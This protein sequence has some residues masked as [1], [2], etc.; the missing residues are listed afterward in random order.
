MPA[1]PRL[2][3]GLVLL[4]SACTTSSFSHPP[5]AQPTDSVTWQSKLDVR[6]PLVATIWDAVALRRVDETELTARVQAAEIVLVGET[7]DNPDHH[8]LEAALISAF[9]A[10]HTS[11]AVVFEMLDRQRQPAVD[12]SLSAHPGDVDM[13]AQAVGW[14]SSG[15]P[16][17]SIYRPVFEAAV[18]ARGTLLAGGL[19]R[20]TAMRIAREGLAAFDP[21]LEQAF[22]LGEPP[23]ADVLAAMRHEMSESHCGLLPEAMLDPMVL[24]QR[25]RDALLAERLYEGAGR[26]HGALLV[27]G[28]GHVRRDRGVPA[29]LQHAYGAKSLAIGLLEARAE[30]VTP[31]GYAESFGTRALPF[32]YVWFTPRASDTDHCAELRE[33][34]R[35]HATSGRDGN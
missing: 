8:R 18:A 27:A 35:A 11:P 20:S 34:M 10:R 29:Q 22:G 26:N 33:R 28:T 16:A 14:A 13:L 15:W 32:D 4:V 25:T 6:H 1:A 12:S 31:V 21:S 3:L 9:A 30:V 7:H 5:A 24:V 23:A 2:A 19:D 17:W